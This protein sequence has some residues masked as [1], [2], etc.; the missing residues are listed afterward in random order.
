M[1]FSDAMNAQKARMDG[2]AAGDGGKPP[3]VSLKEELAMREAKLEQEKARMEHEKAELMERRRKIGEDD[4]EELEDKEDS[5]A[6]TKKEARKLQR[7]REN[8]QR[9]REN[10]QRLREN[11]GELHDG[12]FCSPCVCLGLSPV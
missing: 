10:E 4:L 9:L 2:S 7:L 6:L 5:N 12:A 3:D 1:R 11:D 8:E